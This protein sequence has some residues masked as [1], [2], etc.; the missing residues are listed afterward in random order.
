MALYLQGFF[1]LFCFWYDLMLYKGEE[2]LTALSAFI[3]NVT[4]HGNM[5]T[6]I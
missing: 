2:V 1:C 6:C 4:T 3:C 5:Y